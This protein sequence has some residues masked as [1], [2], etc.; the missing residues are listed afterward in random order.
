M[1]LGI[2]VFRRAA[3]HEGNIGLA[4]IQ[5]LQ[6]FLRTQRWLQGHLDAVLGQRGR[7]LLA[8]FFVGAIV[9]P[10]RQ[11]HLARRRRVDQPVSERAKRAN[12]QQGGYK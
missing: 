11:A 7:V 12:Q 10:R 3:L 2:V 9:L 1:A 8:E 5:A 4:R 6:V